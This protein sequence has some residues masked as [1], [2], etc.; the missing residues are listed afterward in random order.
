M[1]QQQI[2]CVLIFQT[3]TFFSGKGIKTPGL[4][5]CT[6]YGPIGIGNAVKRWLVFVSGWFA[7][8][9]HVYTCM[10]ITRQVQSDVLHASLYLQ[11]YYIYIYVCSA[12]VFMLKFVKLIPVADHRCDLIIQMKHGQVIVVLDEPRIHI[13]SMLPFLS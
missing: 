5:R 7:K 4:R 9:K 10:S 12:M 3:L 6:V 1:N 11:V 8:V 2:T 13:P